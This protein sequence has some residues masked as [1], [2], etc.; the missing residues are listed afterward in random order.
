MK[1]EQFIE[2]VT[3]TPLGIDPS[4]QTFEPSSLPYN[5]IRSATN[6]LVAK[7]CKNRPNP[8][9]LPVGGAHVT[10]DLARVLSTPVSHAERLKTATASP[11][12]P[13]PAP[14]K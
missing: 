7:V 4:A 11:A 1:V 8:M 12:P 10:N 5:I 3:A 9:H 6:T 13:T 2:Q 14:G